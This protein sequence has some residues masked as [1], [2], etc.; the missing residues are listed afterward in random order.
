MHYYA[1]LDRFGEFEP[2][3][4]VMPGDMVGY[5]G[6]TGNA[7]GTPPHLH[8]GVYTA[9]ALNPFPLLQQDLAQLRSSPRA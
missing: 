8:Y 9:G 3:D 7:R 4:L 6:D 2:G 1:H 5:V